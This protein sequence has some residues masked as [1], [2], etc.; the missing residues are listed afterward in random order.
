M[1]RVS[2]VSFSSTLCPMRRNPMLWTTFAC[3]LSKPIVLLTSV[4]LTRP[5]LDIGP[6]PFRCVLVLAAQLAHRTRIAQAGE[7]GEGRAHH[8]VRVGRTQRLGQDVLDAARLD[9]RA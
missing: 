8:V 1:P 7:A 9:H 3:F 4:I 6:R 2:G 5:G